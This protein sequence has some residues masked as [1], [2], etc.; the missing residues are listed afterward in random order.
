MPQLIEQQSGAMQS[1]GYNTLN[2]AEGT[3]LIIRRGLIENYRHHHLFVT[4]LESS[5]TV[6]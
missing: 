3:V 4:P 6:P 2:L 5:S 1:C